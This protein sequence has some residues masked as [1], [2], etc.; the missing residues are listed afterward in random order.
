[1]FR[2]VYGFL[3]DTFDLSFTTAGA[4]DCDVI[5]V[6]GVVDTFDVG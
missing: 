4:L 6:N 2:Y 5:G 1:M 3:H